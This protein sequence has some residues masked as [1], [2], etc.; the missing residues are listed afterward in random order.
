[1]IWLAAFAACNGEGS[2]NVRS[3]SPPPLGSTTAAAPP[4]APVTPGAAP[5]TN[6][7]TVNLTIAWWGSQDRHSRTI[8]AIQLFQQK[9]PNIR[10]NYEYGSNGEYWSRIKV[11]TDPAN[12]PDIIQHDY[13]YIEEWTTKGRLLPLDDLVANGT[14]NMADVP[15]NI[16]EGGRIGGKLMGIGLGTNTQC[17]ILDVDAFKAAGE[18]L[19]PDNW[20]WADFEAISGRLKAK[21][22]I[23]GYGIALHLYTPWR[24]VYL[25]AGSWVFNMPGTALGYTDDLPWINFWKMLLRMQTAGTMVPYAEEKTKFPDSANVEGLPIIT[26]QAAME[27]IHSNQ[28]VAMWNR[29]GDSRTFKLVPIPRVVATGPS[30]YVKPAQYFSIT[31]GS[32]HPKEAAMFI[33]FFTNDLAANE[34]LAAE[35]GVPIST[36]V[37]TALKPTLGKAQAEVFNL[38]ERVNRDARPLPPPD[39]APWEQI[40]NTIYIPKVAEPIMT[41][42]VTPEQGVALFRR[43]ANALLSVTPPP[44][45]SGTR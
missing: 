11:G 43:E 37:L 10:F 12:L 40:R 15:R 8:K 3:V 26:K 5:A 13:A 21:L 42:M 17:F 2:S 30:V 19:P 33:D 41:G 16:V 23:P 22:N 1:V 31:A 4:A 9:H 20:T 45:M 7:A 28:L 39:P 14:I 35:R 18:A 29:A 6:P 36:K 44:I 24:A 38:L 27:Q 25:S 34:A 32:R